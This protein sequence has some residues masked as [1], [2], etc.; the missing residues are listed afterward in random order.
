MRKENLKL[1]ILF[2]IFRMFEVVGNLNIL[3]TLW[4]YQSVHICHFESFGIIYSFRD[5]II[6]IIPMGKTCMFLR[7]LTDHQVS[8][9]L[10]CFQ[11]DFLPLVISVVLHSSFY[12]IGL[13]RNSLFA[14]LWHKRVE[15][16]ERVWSVWAGQEG[17][18]CSGKYHGRHF[19]KG[20]RAVNLVLGRLMGLW[21]SWCWDPFVKVVSLPVE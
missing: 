8:L 19:H 9:Y 1:I 13:T 10:R 2:N 12:D 3:N 11:T 5:D 18:S 15:A 20:I 4:S 17:K 14:E 21:L 6:N 7:T 16:E